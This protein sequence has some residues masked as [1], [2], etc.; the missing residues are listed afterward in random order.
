VDIHAYPT[1]LEGVIV[2]ETAY[3]CDARGFFMESYHQ[4][5]Y[6]A[7]GIRDEFVQDN[8]SRSSMHVLRGLHYQD[9][10]APQA[11]LVR[12]IAGAIWD[13]AVD[14]RLGSPTYG[15]WVGVELTADNKRQMFIPAGFAHGFVALTES[16]EIMYKCTNYYAP[17]AEGGIMWNDPDLAIAWPVDDPVLSERDRRAQSWREYVA[18]PAFHYTHGLA[19]LNGVRMKVPV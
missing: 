11:K 19:D 4:R 5:N 3:A 14:L 8:H 15:Q 16:A 1:K 2:I 18:N 6:A 10:T 9:T 13:V 12:C 7:L 17:E